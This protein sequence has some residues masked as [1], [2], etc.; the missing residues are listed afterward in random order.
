MNKKADIGATITWMAA[1]FVIV[2]ILL[3]LY[4]LPTTLL[5]ATKGGVGKIGVKFEEQENLIVTE[6]QI[7]YL[8]TPLKFED[9][10]EKVEDLF[11]MMQ[12]PYLNKEFLEKINVY[13]N[14]INDLNLYLAGISQETLISYGINEDVENKN[15]EIIKELNK[16]FNDPCRDYII[17][18]PSGYLVKQRG[19]EMI[20]ADYIDYLSDEYLSFFGI[21]KIKFWYKNYPIE[22]IYMERIYC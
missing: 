17:K 22:I 1:F 6:N 10:D 21:S 4:L 20:K 11:L 7:S 3:I 2:F 8:M 5:F 16:I 12:D 14:N 9:K 18:L 13:D 15:K 19:E